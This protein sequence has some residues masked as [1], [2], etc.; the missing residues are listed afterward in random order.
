MFAKRINIYEVLSVNI[1]ATRPTA[2]I[3]LYRAMERYTNKK[4]KLDFK[5]IEFAARSFMDEM[6]IIIKKHPERVFYKTNMNDQVQKMDNL[7]LNAKRRDM[8]DDHS[9]EQPETEDQSDLVSF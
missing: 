7:V 2:R 9:P 5:S 8:W 4:I 6:N 1:L 3:L